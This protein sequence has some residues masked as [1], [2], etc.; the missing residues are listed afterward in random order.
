MPWGES[1]GR[2]GAPRPL[3][4]A[5]PQPLRSPRRA[6]ASLAAPPPGCEASPGLPTRSNTLTPQKKAAWDFDGGQGDAGAGRLGLQPHTGLLPA[7]DSLG[8]VFGTTSL[9]PTPQIQK[10]SLI[11]GT[12]APPPTL[13]VR[14]GRPASSPLPAQADG[15]E[16][17]RRRREE[18]KRR[19]RDLS[20]SPGLSDS[21]TSRARTPG[22]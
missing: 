2:S 15:C 6:G 22:N 19:P 4:P 1:W 8:S 21:R 13:G 5:S 11:Q 18:G 16:T 3:Q 14:R 10:S 7:C 12:R 9:P 20:P 17:W